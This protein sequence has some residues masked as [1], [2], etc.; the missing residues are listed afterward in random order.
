MTGGTPNLYQM[1]VTKGFVNYGV[2]LTPTK[3]DE[4]DLDLFN[5]GNEPLTLTPNSYAF[6]GLD[7]AD[8]SLTK[9]SGGTQC[10][11]TGV[12]TVATGSSC[13]LGPTFTPPALAKSDLTPNI[14]SDSLSVPTN[15]T[16]IGGGGCDARG[17]AL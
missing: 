12:A 15:A 1:N 14:Y 9:P 6:K 7:L 3:A 10:D 5:I 13:S 11:T 16:N 8:Y 4:Q 17:I 2:G